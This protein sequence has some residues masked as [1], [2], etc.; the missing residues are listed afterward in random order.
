[1]GTGLDGTNEIQRAAGHT[2][3]DHDDIGLSFD[4]EWDDSPRPWRQGGDVNTFN[5]GQ[6]ISK[7]GADGI[8]IIDDE[9]LHSISVS[10]GGSRW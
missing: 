7:P 9:K 3:V 1:V 10:S 4:D 8:R 5:L 6:R 2:N